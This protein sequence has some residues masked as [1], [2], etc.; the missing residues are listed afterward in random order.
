MRGR[1]LIYPGP[2]GQV[3]A[4]GDKNCPVDYSHL[5]IQ[6]RAPDAQRLPASGPDACI[7]SDVDVS[8]EYGWDAKVK[9][10]APIFTGALGATEIARQNW[11]HFAVGAALSGVTIVCGENVCGIDPH[12]ERLAAGTVKSAP[13]LD[14]RIETYKRYHRG[15]GEI[16]VQISA[17]DMRL[18]VAPVHP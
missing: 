4:T 11:E 5:N 7:S 1:E 10:S 17:E 2:S 9:M 8:T 15:R 6:T 16:L 13:D 18:G 12:L 3:I 14:R